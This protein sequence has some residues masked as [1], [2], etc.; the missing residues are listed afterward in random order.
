MRTTQTRPSR[1]T[2]A[3]PAMAPRGAGGIRHGFLGCRTAIE[4][5]TQ[6]PGL[7]TH[8]VLSRRVAALAAKV[9]DSLRASAQRVVSHPTLATLGEAFNATDAVV[10]A[11]SSVQRQADQ[12]G[13]ARMRARMELFLLGVQTGIAQLESG[14]ESIPLLPASAPDYPEDEE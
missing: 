3:K 13:S 1:R 6:L 2:K 9:N 5:L 14:L 10:A 7:A 4:D 12:T 8:P 11:C